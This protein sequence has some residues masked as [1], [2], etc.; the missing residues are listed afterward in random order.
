MFFAFLNISFFSSPTFCAKDLF[1]DLTQWKYDLDRITSMTPRKSVLS[2]H[3]FDSIRY[4][5]RRDGEKRLKYSK[6]L[7]VMF[8]SGVF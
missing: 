1:N 7:A 4:N 5:K 3:G 6:V 8:C 2:E